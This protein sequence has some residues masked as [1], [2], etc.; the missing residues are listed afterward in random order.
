MR[1]LPTSSAA[2]GG[3][4]DRPDKHGLGSPRDP[5]SE[6]AYRRFTTAWDQP[7]SATDSGCGLKTW[8]AN[9]LDRR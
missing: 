7:E 4:A 8:F 2:L 1:V 9:S 5:C 3:D 6:A